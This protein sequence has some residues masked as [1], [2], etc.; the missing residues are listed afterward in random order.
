MSPG[1]AISEESKLG[2]SVVRL[3]IVSSANPFQDVF[4]RYGIT[5]IVDKVPPLVS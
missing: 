5:S 2:E 3:L 1:G 4:I